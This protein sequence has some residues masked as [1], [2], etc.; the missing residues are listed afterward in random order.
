MK[1]FLFI[2]FL[3]SCIEAK[4]IKFD[5]IFKKYNLSGTIIISSLNTNKEYIYNEQRSKKRFSPASTFKIPN[6]LISLQ[7]KAVQDEKEMIKWDKKD[8]GWDAWNKDHSIQTAFPV[9]C[10]W[11][12]Q[13][14]AKRVG[15]KKYQNYLNEF[16]YGNKQVGKE[17]T[18]FWLD[19]ELQISA[20]EQIKFLKKLYQNKLSFEKKYIDVLK[21]IMITQ[22]NK[23]HIIHVKT[24]WASKS[25]IGW[26]VGYMEIKDDILFFATNID[27]KE[28][29]EAKYRKMITMQA[30]EEVSPRSF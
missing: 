2:L 24:G 28:L 11:F 13:E 30:L 6:T 14:L 4:D 10:V 21:N 9:S 8:R 15:I 7:E 22:K 20:Q 27:M 19:G 18:S 5:S 23:K 12:Y 26:Y 3:I 1:I 16:N 29:K 25:H 17:L